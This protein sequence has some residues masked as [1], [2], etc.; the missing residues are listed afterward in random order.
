MRSAVAKALAGCGVE[1]IGNG[2]DLFVRK[3]RNVGIGGQET[4]YSAIAIFYAAFLPR[5]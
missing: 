3:E 1:A 4:P 2:L 5:C